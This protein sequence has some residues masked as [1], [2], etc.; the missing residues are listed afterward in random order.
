MPGPAHVAACSYAIQATAKHAPATVLAGQQLVRPFSS[1]CNS[2]LRHAATIVLS[3]V[4]A[5]ACRP[6][7]PLYSLTTQTKHAKGSCTQLCLIANSNCPEAVMAV[8]QNV[9]Q[10]AAQVVCVEARDR[11]GNL[12]AVPQACLRAQATGPQGAVPFSPLEL[13]P[14]DAASKH[15]QQ[16]RRLGATFTVAGSYGLTV[17][18]VDPDTQVHLWVSDWCYEPSWRR[19]VSRQ[20]GPTH[21]ETTPSKRCI[22]ACRFLL[23]RTNVTPATS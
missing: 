20:N 5:P 6:R 15:P 22:R 13:L 18:V 1:K 8:T 19:C 4:S 14:G 2:S 3:S 23:L 9:L 17:C 7:P 21:V 11:Y 16:Q 12:A 10:T